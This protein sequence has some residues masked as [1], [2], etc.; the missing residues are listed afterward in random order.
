MT[1]TFTTTITN[2]Q[3]YPIYQGVVNYVFQI[4]W[5]YKGNDETYNTAM[6]GFTSVPVNDPSS[7]TPY[8]DLTEEQVMGWI[9]EYTDP[10]IWS[11]YSIKI[12]D[13]IAAQYTPTII[14]PPLPWTK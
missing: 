4:N 11:D 5:S 13:W 1:I 7:A 14:T 2:I 10:L 3:A 8:F 12:T 6:S 9:M